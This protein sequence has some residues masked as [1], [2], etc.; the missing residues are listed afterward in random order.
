MFDAEPAGRDQM[1][2]GILAQ[3]LKG[4]LHPGTGCHGS[5]GRA[6]QIRVVEIR[7][8]VRLCLDLTSHATL[9]P[10][11]ARLLGSHPGEEI[12]NGLPIPQDHPVHS[13]RFTGFHGDAQPT[14]GTAE[15]QG[16]L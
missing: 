6:A 12:G 5:T 7:E 11:Q 13:A 10:D 1:R 15:R 9:L 4:T 14:G 3:D 8:P 2:W 16:S